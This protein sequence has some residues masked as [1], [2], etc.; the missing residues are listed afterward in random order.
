MSELTAVELLHADY[1]QVHSQHPATLTGD[2]VRSLRIYAAEL[3]SRTGIDP[4]DSDPG[5]V[6]WLRIVAAL[7][8]FAMKENR[9]ARENR[10]LAPGAISAEERTLV[11]KLRGQRRAFK[12]GR[13]CEY[14]I[15]RLEC[16]PGLSLDPRGQHW[17][18]SYRAYARFIEAHQDTPKAR[19]KV[20][21]E[22]SLAQWA[23]KARMAYRAGTLSQD[24]IDACA[25]L[26]RWT[27]GGAPR[28]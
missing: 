16:I 6:E 22:R 25:N 28:R 23:A 7:E 26:D 11:N 13:L 20:A 14:Q 24:R 9:M 15:R 8:A 21:S 17:D 3:R 19:S 2:Q 12:A 27:W 18:T 4:A 5:I 10:R 1:A